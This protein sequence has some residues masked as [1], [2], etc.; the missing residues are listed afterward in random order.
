MYLCGEQVK[1]FFQW[2]NHLGAEKVT[3]EQ[4]KVWVKSKNCQCNVSGH[5]SFPLFSSWVSFLL[6]DVPMVVCEN[7]WVD[8]FVV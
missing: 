4:V 7:D 6:E 3:L 8:L 1:F 5:S 2:F